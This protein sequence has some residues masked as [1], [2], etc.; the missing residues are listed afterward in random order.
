[1]AIAKYLDMFD[2]DEHVARILP[3]YKHRCELMIQTMR[4]TFPEGIKFTD[5]DGGLF[6]W[7]ELPE[8]INSRELAGACLQKGVAV[9]PGDGFFP[10]GENKHCFRMNYSN[11]TDEQLILGV[12]RLNETIREFLK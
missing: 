11:A 4:E 6:T 8:Y 7:V 2:I 12:H 9:V 5:P 3:V 1:M 10:K